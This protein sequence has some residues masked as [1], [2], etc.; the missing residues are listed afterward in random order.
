VRVKF[1]LKNANKFRFSVRM[2]SKKKDAPPAEKKSSCAHTANANIPAKNV[3]ERNTVIMGVSEIFARI[4]VGSPYVCMS[5][6]FIGA[7]FAIWYVFMA[8][9]VVDAKFVL[10]N[11]N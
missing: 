5:G 8:K 3:G 10:K 9:R 7:A 4:A 2:D 11:A 1:V 6:R